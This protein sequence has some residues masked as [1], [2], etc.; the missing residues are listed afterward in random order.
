MSTYISRSSGAT[1]PDYT[2]ADGVRVADAKAGELGWPGVSRPYKDGE[3]LSAVSIN[4]T[5]HI[6]GAETYVICPNGRRYHVPPERTTTRDGMRG[7]VIESIRH[8]DLNPQRD[9]LRSKTPKR[10]PRPLD[11]T[12]ANSSK[13]QATM[14][15]TASGSTGP[16]NAAAASKPQTATSVLLNLFDPKLGLAPGQAKG[17]GRLV[18]QAADLLLKPFDN[19]LFWPNGERPQQSALQSAV[20]DKRGTLAYYELTKAGVAIDDKGRFKWPNNQ[21]GGENFARLVAAAGEAGD[22]SYANVSRVHAS[23]NQLKTTYGLSAAFVKGY[24]R[25][26]DEMTAATAID[27]AQTL[28][29]ARAAQ[30][31]TRRKSPPLDVVGGAPT[32]VIVND[33]RPIA[34]RQLLPPEPLKQAVSPKNPVTSK[35]LPFEAEFTPKPP[36]LPT[37]RKTTSPRSDQILPDANTIDVKPHSSKV[38][39]PTGRLRSAEMNHHPGNRV[40][41]PQVRGAVLVP[42]E[43]TS[44]NPQKTASGPIKGPLSPIARSTNAPVST[45]KAELPNR[46]AQTGTHPQSAQMAPVTVGR[47]LASAAHL[48]AAVNQANPA[49][50]TRP[51][52]ASRDRATQQSAPV[53]RSG[54]L[55]R[56]KTPASRPTEA[57]HAATDGKPSLT[58]PPLITQRYWLPSIDP[59]SPE[60]VQRADELNL[61]GLPYGLRDHKLNHEAGRLFIDSAGGS[62]DPGRRLPDGDPFIGPYRRTRAARMRLPEPIS[63]DGRPMH[64]VGIDP[65]GTMRLRSDGWQKRYMPLRLL[66][67]RT[68][69]YQDSSWQITGA[70]RRGY[71]LQQPS[72]VAGAPPTKRLVPANEAAQ[73]ELTFPG[74]KRYTLGPSAHNSARLNPAATC[75][76]VTTKL[77]V[78]THFEGYLRGRELDG[79][80][81]LQVANQHGGFTARGIGRSGE[82]VQ[83]DVTAVDLVPT[84]TL[85]DTPDFGDATPVSS[86]LAAEAKTRARVVPILTSDQAQSRGDFAFGSLPATQA[87]A[88]MTNTEYTRMLIDKLRDPATRGD[89]TVFTYRAELGD[90]SSSA[91]A[92][93]TDYRR[94]HPQA[95]VRVIATDIDLGNGRVHAERSVEGA[96]RA[97]EQFERD[98][99]VQLA[100]PSGKSK[101]FFNHAKG[102]VNTHPDGT[103]EGWITTASLLLDRRKV[104]AVIP[105]SATAAAGV[106][107]FID[108]AL[109]HNAPIN[110]RRQLVSELA[111]Q[112]LLLDDVSTPVAAKAIASLIESAHSSLYVRVNELRDPASTRRLIAAAERGCAVQIRYRKIDP[113][114]ESLLHEAER[115]LPELSHRD[116]RNLHPEE[117]YSHAN[118]IVADHR[119]A[120]VGSAFFWGPM[121][122]EKSTGH[123]AGGLEAG[124]LLAFQDPQQARSLI[125]NLEATRQ[126]P[127]AVPPGSDPLLPPFVRPRAERS[128]QPRPWLIEGRQ[129]DVVSVQPAAQGPASLEITVRP[130][131]PTVR[132]M[133][134]ETLKTKVLHYAGQDWHLQNYDKAGLR[135]RAVD[136]GREV[137]V[138]PHS[139]GTVSVRLGG[140]A[141]Y[142][143][144]RL[145]YGAIRLHPVGST[146]VRTLPLQPQ[147]TFEARL[148]DH[149]LDGPFRITMLDGGRARASGFDAQGR[150]FTLMLDRPAERIAPTFTE[151]ASPDHGDTFLT[152]S[153][154]AHETALRNT[155]VISDISRQDP[156]LGTLLTPALPT[157]GLGGGYAAHLVAA[158]RNPR[159]SG[160][161]VIFPK[162]LSDRTPE[163]AAVMDALYD[164]R[165]RHPKAR[166][167]LY[168]S[169]AVIGPWVAESNDRQQANALTDWLQR[170][171]GIELVMPSHSTKAVNAHAK[172]FIVGDQATFTSGTLTPD[173]LRKVDYFMDL[174]PDVTSLVR[175][176]VRATFDPNTP[177][178]R[179]R[180]LNASLAKAGI[181]FDDPKTR[182]SMVTRALFDLVTHARRSLYI[183]LSDMLDPPF[184]AQIIAAAQRGVH[185]E[186]R[187]RTIDAASLAALQG[188]ATRNPSLM[189]LRNVAG[190]PQAPNYTHYNTVVADRERAYIGSGYSWAAVRE[191][192]AHFTTG[193]DNGVLLRSKRVGELRDL[194]EPAD[195][196]ANP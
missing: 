118:V 33:Q 145:L 86:F 68:V 154:V 45:P 176:Y 112:G 124:A 100:L 187:Y 168:T 139:S 51:S 153:F 173:A 137:T 165:A 46:R 92:A 182:T 194:L 67:A 27:T 63:V 192:S 12:V 127:V 120:Y 184:A 7:W 87:P 140:Q 188:E 141:T 64:L 104:D 1:S 34:V 2:A 177:A 95:Q 3:T 24:I 41:N 18:T 76:V 102:F 132:S 119:T 84:Y 98:T 89:I 17:F 38:I 143:L 190:T 106:G 150:P 62:V 123:A 110:Q 79:P 16:H 155:P 9:V 35:S 50:Q 81:S 146:D 52:S 161:V 90:D 57:R 128:A 156:T 172:G 66:S 105:L 136:D 30:P 48:S 54:R 162:S 53:T 174:P 149:L 11:T 115:R 126:L 49:S 77:P 147:D 170:T 163:T 133:P 5:V 22:R 101:G 14:R 88:L 43:R 74:G 180:F 157:V 167:T 196:P 178:E 59:N 47:I 144:G 164:Y 28:V 55:P 61:S 44:R 181:L 6:E 29:T 169:L 116:V 151:L 111:K 72:D 91:K 135:L 122:A 10:L 117:S 171:H 142:T 166:I 148:H 4:L 56:N 129:Y 108:A 94:R 160:D 130:R 26:L 23:L 71:H 121:L 75:A 83:L 159:N 21:Q 20:H 69:Q 158:L 93:L 19:P 58:S 65:D 113:Q 191:K 107:R 96:R 73:I 134:L 131:G 60:G 195:Q 85:I 15:P 109:I 186:I 138:P 193:W 97:A 8:H 103:S 42:P 40:T 32:K 25:T 99:G 125:E 189:N 13:S 80:Y 70:D 114:S 175:D 39:R 152:D 185:V 78:G 82:P 183:R 36:R 179:L 31:Q 37:A